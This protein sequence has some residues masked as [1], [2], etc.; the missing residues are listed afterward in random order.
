MI[1]KCLLANDYLATAGSVF[2]TVHRTQTESV[3]LGFSIAGIL[4]LNAKEK[5][6]HNKDYEEVSKVLVWMHDL[7]GA[8]HSSRQDEYPGMAPHIYNPI[9]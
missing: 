8:K 2:C 9:T 3:N 5:R 4:T 1:S 7:K 6:I